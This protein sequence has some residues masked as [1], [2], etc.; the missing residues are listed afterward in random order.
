MRREATGQIETFGL[1]HAG[2]LPN[3]LPKK[4]TPPYDSCLFNP[5]Q[6]TLNR[7]LTHSGSVHH[8]LALVAVSYPWAEHF[9]L[10][11]LGETGV[12]P[13]ISWPSATAR[14]ALPTSRANAE[15]FRPASPII[16]I[17]LPELPAALSP[18]NTVLVRN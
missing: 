6:T 17:F 1:H 18:E 5:I 3:V 11:D 15:T 7:Y 16:A 13:P 9:H 2:R 10:S 8:R 14:K 4:P 12:G